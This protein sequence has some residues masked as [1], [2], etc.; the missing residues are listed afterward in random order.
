MKKFTAVR[1]VEGFRD[2]TTST[3]EKLLSEVPS[4]P[5]LEKLANAAP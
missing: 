2:K 3:A 5:E 4:T 1:K